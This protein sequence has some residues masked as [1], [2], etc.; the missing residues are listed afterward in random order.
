[1]RPWRAEGFAANP[2]GY[3][4]RPHDRGGGGIDSLARSMRDAPSAAS[5]RCWRCWRRPNPGQHGREF[6][7]MLYGFLLVSGNAYVERVDM[8]D[9]PRELYA[10]RPDRVKAVASASGW[11]EAYRILR[12]RTISSACRAA[13]CCT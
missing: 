11:P 9:A 1:M 13:R 7:E 3:R 8:D 4:S 12:Q 5:I 10:L 2:V 6:L